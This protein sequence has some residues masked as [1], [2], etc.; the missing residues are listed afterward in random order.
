MIRIIHMTIVIHTKIRILEAGRV[1]SMEINMVMMMMKP[2]AKTPMKTLL[3]MIKT[4]SMTMTI[5]TTMT[6]MMTTTP[7]AAV[8][9]ITT[10]RTVIVIHM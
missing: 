1:T 3:M 4:P 7:T 9:T 6:T 8:T 2:K 10:A 5:H